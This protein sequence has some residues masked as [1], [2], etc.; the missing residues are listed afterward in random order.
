MVS[1][2]SLEAVE[3]YKG[4]IQDYAENCIRRMISKINDGKAEIYFDQGCKISVSISVDKTKK[5]AVFDFILAPCWRHVSRQHELMLDGQHGPILEANMGSC[6][7]AKTVILAHKV[8]ILGD[9]AV[10]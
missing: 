3:T 7:R 1:Q 9:R 6:R 2:F 4:Y 10:V 5:T 8:C